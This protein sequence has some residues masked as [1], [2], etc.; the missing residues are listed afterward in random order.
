MTWKQIIDTNNQEEYERKAIRQPYVFVFY[1]PKP[2]HLPLDIVFSLYEAS[3]VLG[4]SFSTVDSAFY[5]QKTVGGVIMRKVY[6]EDFEEASEA[7]A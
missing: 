1:D 3:V 6:T 7:T 5:R 2:P 4:V